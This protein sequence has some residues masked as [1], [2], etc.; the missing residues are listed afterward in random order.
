MNPIVCNLI[1]DSW[2][3]CSKFT[4]LNNHRDHVAQFFVV[5]N[6]IQTTT[7]SATSTETIQKSI[8]SETLFL[9]SEIY[10]S[11]RWATPKPIV[12]NVLRLVFYVLVFGHAS[13]H[14]TMCYCCIFSFSLFIY[15]QLTKPHLNHVNMLMTFVKGTTFFRHLK[16]TCVFWICERLCGVVCVCVCVVCEADFFASISYSHS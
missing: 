5:F 8:C 6:K 14:G 13:H 3:N 4:K 7:T 10:F 16:I 11:R 15:A 9:A 1:S 2:E 12:F